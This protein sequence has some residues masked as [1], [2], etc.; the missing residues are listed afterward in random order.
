MAYALGEYTGR[1]LVYLILLMPFVFVSKGLA[2]MFGKPIAYVQAWKGMSIGVVLA[3][4][5]VLGVAFLRLPPSGGLVLAL[6]LISGVITTL[7]FSKFAVSMDGASYS[8]VQS[9]VIGTFPI[10]LLV[11]VAG[12]LIP[13]R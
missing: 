11:L 8:P 3:M 1:I 5:F 6:V 12:A 2:R 10:I 4:V 7:S 9:L 13:V